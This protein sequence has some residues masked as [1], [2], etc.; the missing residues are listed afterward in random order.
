M[1]EAGLK[2]AVKL[3]TNLRWVYGFKLYVYEYGIVLWAM[4]N[5]EKIQNGTNIFLSEAAMLSWVVLL[6][7]KTFM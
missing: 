4:N 2:K 5:V 7:A 1:S 3:D 6:T